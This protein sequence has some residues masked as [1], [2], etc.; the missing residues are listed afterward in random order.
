MKLNK[1]QTLIAFAALVLIAIFVNYSGITGN[2]VSTTTISVTPQQVEENGIITITITP[3]LQGADREMNIY[4]V[5]PSQDLRKARYQYC[6]YEG[7]TCKETY[8]FKY[9]LSTSDA[10][11]PGQYYV[12]VEGKS[13]TARKDFTII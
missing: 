4:K 2:A 9:K 6:Q 10:F 3:G 8:T 7:A 11:E 12:Q 5:K 13:G 1:N